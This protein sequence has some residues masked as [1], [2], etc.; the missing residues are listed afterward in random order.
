MWN[1]FRS[2]SYFQHSLPSATPGPCRH[3]PLT[4]TLVLGCPTRC[5]C[6]CEIQCRHVWFQDKEPTVSDPGKVP[7]VGAPGARCWVCIVAANT[8]SQG[9]KDELSAAWAGCD[10]HREE[11]VWEEGLGQEW[12]E[13][14]RQGM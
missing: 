14:Q 10:V 13:E 9:A 2:I 5:R 8:A 4:E 12:Q 1:W 3:P 6:T 11:E 7:W